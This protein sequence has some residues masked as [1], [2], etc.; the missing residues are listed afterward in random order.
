MPQ[1][2]DEPGR[3]VNVG[4]ARTQSFNTAQDLSLLGQKEKDTDPFKKKLSNDSA[5]KSQKDFLKDVDSF[6]IQV[7]DELL[8][9]EEFSGRRFFET[10]RHCQKNPEI[11][12]TSRG[13]YSKTVLHYILEHMHSAIIEEG[14]VA[15]MRTVPKG[16]REFLECLIISHPD[17]LI[18]ND[19]DKIGPLDVAAKK[20]KPLIFVVMDLVLSE[21]QLTRLPNKACALKSKVRAN[22]TC[23]IHLPSALDF[24]FR[25][26]EYPSSE[27]CIHGRLDVERLEKWMEN[28][29]KEI[30]PSALGKLEHKS[31]HDSILHQLLERD[32]FTQTDGESKTDAFQRLIELCPK[33]DLTTADNEGWYPLHKTIQLYKEDNI[34]FDQ[35]FC[36][37]QT[38]IRT[39]PESIYVNGGAGSKV[40]PYTLLRD[41]KPEKGSAAFPRSKGK[42]D[43]WLKAEKL[44]KLT[45]IGDSHDRA[46]KIKYLYGGIKNGAFT[47]FSWPL[48]DI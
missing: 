8:L 33:K 38:I 4:L 41:L 11:K 32:S 31:R 14:R 19:M 5:K 36:V 3:R 30:L 43:S 46:T 17:L 13:R 34:D 44:L 12:I 42:L 47:V 6:F 9:D 39:S 40:N 22:E 45:C 15:L 28:F 2:E 1:P 18:S 27:T 21:E 48:R 24:A 26:K 37:I 25:K 20:V 7:A 29:K 16:L 23:S 35:L 10:K